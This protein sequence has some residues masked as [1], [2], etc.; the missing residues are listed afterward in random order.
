[1]FKKG[2]GISDIAKRRGIKEGTV[3]EHL[4]L[5]IE[6]NQLKLAKV[7][8]AEKIRKILSHLKDGTEKVSQVKSRIADSAITYNEL[9]CA[10]AH[11]RKEQR[12]KSS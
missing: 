7:L 8:A 6:Y 1:M 12:K 5:L 3:W 10:L 9:A 11:V 4:A 2:L